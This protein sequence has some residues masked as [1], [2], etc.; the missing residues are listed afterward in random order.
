LADATAGDPISG[1]KWTRKTVR[2]L[3]RELRRRQI[4]VGRTTVRRLLQERDY[5]LR[6]NRK[7]RTKQHDPHRDRQ[8][9]YIARTRR[10]FQKAGFPG[11]S[12]DCKKK[13]LVGN[14]RNPGRTW[15]RKPLEVLA[16][17][18]PRDAEGKAIPWT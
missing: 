15:R 12:V 3:S 6:V 10:A 5:V 7:R 16:T 1:V 13:E 18:F 14:F 9:R 17:D 8:M 11:I 2:R 4:K